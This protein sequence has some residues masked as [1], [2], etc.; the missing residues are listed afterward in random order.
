MRLTD[1]SV[2]GV[3][4]QASIF[5]FLTG[6]F[7]QLS[8]RKSPTQ[9]AIKKII[10]HP[11]TAGNTLSYFNHITLKPLVFRSMCAMLRPLSRRTLLTVRWQC[12]DD[13]TDMIRTSHTE[14]DSIRRS[15][16]IQYEHGIRRRGHVHYMVHK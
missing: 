10:V 13:A 14:G 8:L 4:M 7:R 5:F 6:H 2:S 15:T 16:S 9:L 3:S 11:L 1:N 12:D